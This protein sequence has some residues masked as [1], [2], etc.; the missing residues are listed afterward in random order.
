MLGPGPAPRLLD[1]GTVPKGQGLDTLLLFKN[2]HSPLELFAYM[3]GTGRDG[4]ERRRREE[5]EG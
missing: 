4:G 5:R 1:L 3:G 2:M